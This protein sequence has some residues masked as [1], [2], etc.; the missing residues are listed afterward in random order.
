MTCR[1]SKSPDSNLSC[2]DFPHDKIPALN[3][4]IE[5]DPAASETATSSSGVDSSSE[6]LEAYLNPWQAHHAVLVCQ[7]VKEMNE[8][9][10]VL[11]PKRLTDEQFW[12]IYFSVTRSRL[13]AEAFDV[14]LQRKVA[15]PA[16]SSEQVML[17]S[18]GI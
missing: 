11:V 3:P 18:S 5:T 14:S 9:R 12:A 4:D 13:P 2:R 7:S 16:Q 1:L 10:F 8:L 17:I 15:P 6:G